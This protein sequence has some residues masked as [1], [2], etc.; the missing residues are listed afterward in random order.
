MLKQLRA[1]G[2]EVVREEDEKGVG[3]FAWIDD[4]EGNRVELWQPV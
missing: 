3:K 2:V 1:A 4:P